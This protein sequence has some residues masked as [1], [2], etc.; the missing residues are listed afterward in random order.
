MATDAA[1]SAPV[2]K[3]TAEPQ[4]AD[5]QALPGSTADPGSGD[6]ATIGAARS[7]TDD[8]TS[9]ALTLLG[10]VLLGMAV[11]VLLLTWLARRMTRH[12]PLP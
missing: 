3:A 7:P 11:L 6:E 9:L 2:A 1:G 12:E 4:V 5:V 8:D 10:I